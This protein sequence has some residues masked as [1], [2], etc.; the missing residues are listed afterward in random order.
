MKG[1]AR[2]ARGGGVDPSSWPGVDGEVTVVELLLL[3][4]KPE[5]EVARGFPVPF[6][7][8]EEPI[9]D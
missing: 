8:I 5:E 9:E 6:D 3:D 4:L 7:R 1:V 2:T